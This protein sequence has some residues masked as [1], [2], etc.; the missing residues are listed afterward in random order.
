MS[1]IALTVKGLSEVLLSVSNVSTII[2]LMSVLPPSLP[3]SR[4]LFPAFRKLTNRPKPE[5]RTSIHE[6]EDSRILCGFDHILKLP[7]SRRAGQ[8]R[9]FSLRKLRREPLQTD[10]GKTNR[11]HRAAQLHA[12]ACQTNLKLVDSK[13]G[14]C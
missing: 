6:N 10:V 11:G 1:R 9:D 13:T 14:P 7:V 3:L 5:L 2:G 8:R 4:H 12:P